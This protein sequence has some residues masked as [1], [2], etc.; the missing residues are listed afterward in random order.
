MSRTVPGNQ[1]VKMR[2]Q[3]ECPLTPALSPSEGA[4]EKRRSSEREPRAGGR[5]ALTAITCDGRLL[6]PRPRGGGEGQGE[7]DIQLLRFAQTQT[8]TEILWQ[9]Y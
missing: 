5:S 7:G 6:F 3:W 9:R 1:E 2:M 8:T 4:R